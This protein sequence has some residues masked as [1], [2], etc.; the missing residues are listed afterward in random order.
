[1]HP[2]S[3]EG[4]SNRCGVPNELVCEIGYSLESA[5]TNGQPFPNFPEQLPDRRPTIPGY[6]KDSPHVPGVKAV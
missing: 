5:L 1:M 4:R 3:L 2:T 6:T